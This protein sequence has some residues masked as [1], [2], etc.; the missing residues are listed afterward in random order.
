MAPEQLELVQ[1]VEA[2]VLALVLVLVPVLALALAPVLALALALVLVLALARPLVLARVPVQAREQALALKEEK[3]A[4]AHGLQQ[5]AQQ[6]RAVSETQTVV[7]GQETQEG[8]E[9]AR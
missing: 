1:D 2:L 6:A 5:K 7:Q 8:R 9:G 4:K 3:Q